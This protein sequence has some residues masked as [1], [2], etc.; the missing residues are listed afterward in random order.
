MALSTHPLLLQPG[1]FDAGEQ[2][3]DISRSCIGM[4]L[5]SPSVQ[6]DEGLGAAEVSAPR[7]QASLLG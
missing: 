1:G 6:R 2:G 3:S 4:D 5:M 7:L